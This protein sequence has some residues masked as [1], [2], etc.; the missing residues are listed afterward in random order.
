MV[1]HRRQFVLGSGAVLASLRWSGASRAQSSDIIRI[2]HITD[3]S[4]AYRDVQGPTGVACAQLAVDE[5][6]AANPGIKVDLIVGDHQNKPD[7]GLGLVRRWIDQEGVDLVTNLGN[8]AL[9]LAVRGVVADKDKVAIVTSAATSELTGPGCSTNLLHWTYDTWSLAHATPTGVVATGGGSWFFV[10][11]DYA[12]GHAAQADITRFVEKAG[13]KVLGS[14]RYPYGSTSD[15]SSFLLQA[16]NSNAKVICFIN[17]GSDLVNCMK[18]AQEFGLGR[19]GTKFAAAVGLINDIA[20]MGLETAQGLSVAEAFYWDLNDRTRLLESKLRSRIG[21][22]ILPNMTQA[23]DYSA[24]T[25]YL[26]A[27]K[28]IGV[29]KAKSSGRGVIEMIKNIPTD[30]DAFG[31]GMVRPDGRK[32]HAM[33]VFEVKS[34]GESKYPGDL[35]RHLSSIPSDQAFR[36]MGEGGCPLL[37]I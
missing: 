34:P 21:A 11:A 5:F 37:K 35:Y 18:Q 25:H 31:A 17:S 36:P 28:A 6:T 3:M 13:G 19:N 32:I 29:Q 23:G 10:T 4:G 14:V 20:A 33:H 27:V 15:F 26:K 24:V 30:D 9:A 16:Q 22:Q 7:I 12:F 8:S 1:I 2:G